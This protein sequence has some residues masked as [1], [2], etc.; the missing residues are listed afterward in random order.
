MGIFSRIGCACALGMMGTRAIAEPPDGVLASQKTS[1]FMVLSRQEEISESRY[2]MFSAEM[3]EDSKESEPKKNSLERGIWTYG[4]LNY[5]DGAE[6]TQTV[7]VGSIG[8]TQELVKDLTLDVGADINRM[9]SVIRFEG[10]FKMDRTANGIQGLLNWKPLD[11]LIL[12]AAGASMRMKDVWLRGYDFDGGRAISKG[13]QKGKMLVGVLAL[14]WSHDLSEDVTFSPFA[15]FEVSQM[16]LEPYTETTGPLPL[17]YHRNIARFHV[18]KLG[19]ELSGSLTDRHDLYV[20]AAWAHQFEKHL[21]SVPG[22]DP[23][24]NEVFD[25]GAGAPAKQDWA[26]ISM[27]FS[28]MLSDKLTLAVIGVALV[29]GDFQPQ[30]GGGVAISRDF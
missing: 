3:L 29:G 8:V 24:K 21:P 11:N 14:S 26:E 15:H 6:A 1:Q 20:G 5:H 10:G 22:F 12:Q 25:M 17:E 23:H 18:A 2:F 7:Y 9:S 13:E 27:G 28:N 19:A 4:V 16:K 30:F